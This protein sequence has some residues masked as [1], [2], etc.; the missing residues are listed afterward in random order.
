[1]AGQA[2]GLAVT[3]SKVIG[4]EDNL[5]DSTNQRVGQQP[6][7]CKIDEEAN[8]VVMCMRHKQRRGW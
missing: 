3:V 7:A 4:K 1:M 5:P 2:R 8:G 6:D